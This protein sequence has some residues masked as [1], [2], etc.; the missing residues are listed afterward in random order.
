MVVASGKP[1]AGEEH[2]QGNQTTQQGDERVIT[3]PIYRD[4]QSSVLTP[5][6][7][8]YAETINPIYG[9]PPRP[10]DITSR[11]QYSHLSEPQSDNSNEVQ[12]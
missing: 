9:S 10:V 5:G 8:E 3:N 6:E 4:N 7:G 11:D 1:Q 2:P 12:A